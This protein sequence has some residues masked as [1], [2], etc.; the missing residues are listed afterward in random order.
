VK[1]AKLG[2]CRA[3]TKAEENAQKKRHVRRREILDAAKY[4]FAEHGF[5]ATKISEIIKRA[6]I[7]RG[8]FYLYFDS[9]DAVFS[10]ILTNTIEEL[11][12]R[13]T[14]VAVGKNAPPPAEQLHENVSRVLEY[15]IADRPLVHL[16]LAHGLSPDTS[17]AQQVDA[18]F[19]NITSLI[20]SSLRYGIRVGLLRPCDVSLTAAQILGSVQGG[21][22]H[23]LQKQ[24]PFEVTDVASNLIEFV[25]HGVLSS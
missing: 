15:M 19:S 1:T 13:I 18:F 20:K 8:T 17:M 6:S 25:L 5:H 2:K 11:Q 4:V 23:L 7:A 21:V 10:S 14:P 24:E 16:L 9:K 12:A 3:V 22:L